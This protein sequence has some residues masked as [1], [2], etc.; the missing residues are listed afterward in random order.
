MTLKHRCRSTEWPER[1]TTASCGKTLQC[2]AVSAA[3][4]R[5]ISRIDSSPN[6]AAP[7]YI[8]LLQSPGSSCAVISDGSVGEG[9]HNSEWAI[10]TEAVAQAVT[11]GPTCALG[12]K[13]K[14]KA[15]RQHKKNPMCQPALFLC[16]HINTF[17][18]FSHA[19]LPLSAKWKVQMKV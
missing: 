8:V 4:H 5:D 14:L 13:L 7:F 11:L 1:Q 3:R 15:I 12:A 16:R 6:K 9:F 10:K 19:D 18:H 2:C 17:D